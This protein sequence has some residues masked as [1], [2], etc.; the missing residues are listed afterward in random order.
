[1]PNG[2]LST[3]PSFDRSELAGGRLAAQIPVPTGD[4][5]G[6]PPT[7]PCKRGAFEAPLLR[8]WRNLTS[9]RTG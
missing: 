5:E 8:D 2:E 6:R 9:F 3:S 1:M 7:Q 4:A